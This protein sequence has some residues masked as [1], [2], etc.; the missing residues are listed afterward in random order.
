MRYFMI[1]ILLI[2]LYAND[3]YVNRAKLL[4][5]NNTL[6]HTINAIPSDFRKKLYMV[7]IGCKYT[8]YNLLQKYQKSKIQEYFKMLASKQQIEELLLTTD[9]KRKI[10]QNISHLI[11]I[12]HLRKLQAN[13]HHHKANLKNF[14]QT[15]IN[16]L[17][18]ELYL[19]KEYHIQPNYKLYS[20]LTITKALEAIT[21]A[22]IHNYQKS[23][24]KH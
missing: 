1:L 12:Q 23:G 13:L 20:K 5:L 16:A 3:M 15:I 18:T 10:D 11:I 24:Y 17:K 6:I 9:E 2:N 21:N 22:I 19:I 4:V 14:Y 8:T 7:E